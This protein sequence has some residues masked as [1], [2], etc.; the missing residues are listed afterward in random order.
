MTIEEAIKKAIEGGYG[1]YL[2]TQEALMMPSGSVVSLAGNPAPIFLD[3]SFWVA[4]AEARHCNY[5][6]C[7]KCGASKQRWPGICTKNDCGGEYSVEWLDEWHRFIDHVAA[8]KTAEEFFE[9]LI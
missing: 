6:Y 5:A 9:G 8:G 1:E 2:L 7:K 4:L 3:P